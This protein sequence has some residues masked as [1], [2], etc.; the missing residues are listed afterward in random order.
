MKVSTLL[1]PH[2][3]GLI[4]LLAGAGYLL[5]RKRRR[6][7]PHQ[8]WAGWPERWTRVEVSSGVE[9][10][11]RV[12]CSG[13]LKGQRRGYWYERYS[14]LLGWWGEVGTENTG[15]VLK[16]HD[17]LNLTWEAAEKAGAPKRPE[18]WAS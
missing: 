6:R 4:G 14:N 13:R 5:N 8:K 9:W 18:G 12:R 2:I 15:H 17:G 7:P 1:S 10:R 16:Y 11:C 3:F